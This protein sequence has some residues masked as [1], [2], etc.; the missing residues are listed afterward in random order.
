MK[1]ALNTDEMSR[2]A[3]TSFADGECRKGVVRGVPVPA[4]L[5]KVEALKPRKGDGV[6]RIVEEKTE[7]PAR[8]H[9]A[10]A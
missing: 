5:L 1:N 4:H 3:M 7:L 9:L 2:L 8:I 10:S 6:L